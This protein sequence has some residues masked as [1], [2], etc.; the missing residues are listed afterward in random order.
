VPVVTIIVGLLLCA[1]G[2]T[3]YT[4]AVEYF[5]RPYVSVTAL[6]PAFVGVI[7][8]VCGVLALDERRLKHA[9]HA[10]AA[11]GLLGLLGALAR[12]VPKLPAVLSGGTGA[13]EHPEAFRSQ[14]AMG[15]VCAVFVALC[16]NSFIQ[17]RRRRARAGG[18]AGPPGAAGG[19]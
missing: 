8:V 1:L 12:A 19:P 13:L 9:M 6:I 2:V 3:S 18:V 7:L 14:V 11:V 17:A 15:V 4:G 10:A 5:G 16:V